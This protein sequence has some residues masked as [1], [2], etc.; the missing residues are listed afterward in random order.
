MIFSVFAVFVETNLVGK[1]DGKEVVGKIIVR[2][3]LKVSRFAICIENR[4]CEDLE[5]GKVYRLLPDEAA[6]REGYLRIVDESA[7][8]YLYPE[9]YFVLLDLPQKAQ[10]AFML[11]A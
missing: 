3:L 11:S 4:D 9:S 1:F 6:D 5:K 10:K 7:E 8:D 2:R